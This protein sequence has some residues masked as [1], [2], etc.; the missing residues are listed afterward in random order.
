MWLFASETC[1]WVGVGK[2]IK[3]YSYLVFR[4]QEVSCILCLKTWIIQESLVC[5]D[6]LIQQPVEFPT[7]VT[8]KSLT[9]WSRLTDHWKAERVSYQ[10]G[11]WDFRSFGQSKS[12]KLSSVQPLFCPGTEF[13]SNIDRQNPVTSKLFVGWVWISNRLKSGRVSH[14]FAIQTQGRIPS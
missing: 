14:L 1:V 9:V 8:R 4:C 2:L 6:I 13:S 11:I 7:T 5:P 12:Q 10:F 3:W